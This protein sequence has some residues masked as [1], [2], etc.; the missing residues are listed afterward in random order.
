MQWLPWSLRDKT[1]YSTHSAGLCEK[2]LPASSKHRGTKRRRGRATTCGCNHNNATTCNH[3]RTHARLDG[4]GEHIQW[5][6]L[7]WD[8]RRGVAFE[9]WLITTRQQ[10][11]GAWMDRCADKWAWLD[12]WMM[13]GHGYIWPVALH[14]IEPF[15]CRISGRDKKNSSGRGECDRPGVL[16]SINCFP[17]KT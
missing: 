8:K 12:R 1:P 13:C 4:R 17:D 7:D 3:L 15:D 10:I 11:R 6:M 16:P 14:I 9:R 2:H 5:R